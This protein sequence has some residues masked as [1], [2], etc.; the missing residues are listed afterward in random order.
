M[1]EQK[2]GMVTHFFNRISV[3][4]LQLTDTLQL[5]DTVHIQGHSSNFT[6]VVESMQIEHETVEKAGPGQD[7]A[8]RVKEPVH[9]DDTVYKVV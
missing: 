8:I 7:V 1:A 3:A 2:I 6:Q 9:E 4:A 5:G